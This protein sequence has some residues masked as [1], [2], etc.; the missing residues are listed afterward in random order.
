MNETVKKN[1][2]VSGI[3]GL[4]LGSL[5]I[6]NFYIG[7]TKR[8]AVQITLTFL[9]IG[10]IALSYIIMVFGSV[11]F[12]FRQMNYVLD[13][14]YMGMDHGYM[15]SGAFVGFL[16]VFFFIFI[17]IGLILV[18]GTAI[19]GF[20]EGALILTGKMDKDGKGEEFEN[21]IPEGQKSKM[22]AAML[23]ITLGTLGVHNFY[24][25][26]VGRGVGQI[27]LTTLGSC[28]LIGPI[29]AF[30]WSLVESIQLFKGSVEKDGKGNPLY[31]D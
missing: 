15:G 6:H 17:M 31:Q 16:M 26:R 10:I 5:G 11:F 9:G 13:Y 25:G 21:P 28:L 1:R 23:G 2:I 27:L 3:L 18:A 24:L 4:V 19:W 22:A 8:G 14:N 30:I 12:L 20:V 29:I 7:K